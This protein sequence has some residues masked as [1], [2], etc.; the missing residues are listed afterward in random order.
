MLSDPYNFSGLAHTVVRLQKLGHSER[1]TA[2]AVVGLCFD[3]R[4]W[5]Y[6]GHPSHC[7]STCFING[8]QISFA[9]IDP[10]LNDDGTLGDGCWPRGHGGLWSQLV[11]MTSHNTLKSRTPILPH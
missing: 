4:S 11:K 3:D 5:K 7:I 6:T 10:D 8:L 9:D 1:N 2:L